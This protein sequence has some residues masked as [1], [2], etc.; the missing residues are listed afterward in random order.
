MFWSL[1][2]RRGAVTGDDIFHVAAE[3]IARFFRRKPS[4]LSPLGSPIVLDVEEGDRPSM[5]ERDFTVRYLK[6]T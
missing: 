1:D 2:A 5:L 4:T 6:R 3:V